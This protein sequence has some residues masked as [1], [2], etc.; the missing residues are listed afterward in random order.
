M[1]MHIYTHTKTLLPGEFL[2]IF[3]FR[4]RNGKYIE[5]C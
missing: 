5:K 3:K 1:I 2:S 4:K